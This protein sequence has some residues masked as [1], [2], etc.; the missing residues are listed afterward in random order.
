MFWLFKLIQT[1][2]I[3]LTN[4]QENSYISIDRRIKETKNSLQK[5]QI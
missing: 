2:T 3:N 4:L 5:L 1:L